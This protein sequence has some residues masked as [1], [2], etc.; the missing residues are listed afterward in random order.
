MDDVLAYVP[1]DHVMP[2][3]VDCPVPTNGKINPWPVPGCA[4]DPIRI[5]LLSVEPVIAM[6]TAPPLRV[7]VS[8]RVG[9]VVR[10]LR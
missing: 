1:S 3:A 7:K 6:A 4:P 9:A 10:E 5:W 8:T 2:L